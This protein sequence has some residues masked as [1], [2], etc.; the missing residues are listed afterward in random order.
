MMKKVI[1]LGLATALLTLVK[2]DVLAQCGLPWA[3]NYSVTATLDDWQDCNIGDCYDPLA[4][5]FSFDACSG[6]NHC[7]YG[8]FNGAC[9]QGTVRYGMVGP[10]FI[11]GIGGNG[12]AK[13]DLQQGALTVVGTED[14]PPDNAPYNAHFTWVADATGE[15]TFDWHYITADGPQYDP[16]YYDIG[17][18][19][20]YLTDPLGAD[21]QSGSATVFLQEGQ[22]LNLG[23][24]SVDGFFAPGIATFR[25]FTSP[26]PIPGCTNPQACNYNNISNTDDGTCFYP[27]GC[28]DPLAENYVANA[29]CEETCVYLL[30]CGRIGNESAALV[31]G[32][33]GDLDIGNWT[34]DIDSQQSGET[35]IVNSR[36]IVIST[37]GIDALYGLMSTSVTVQEDGAYVFPVDLA[38]RN[39]VDQWAIFRLG[40]NGAVVTPPE[41][42]DE[43]DNFVEHIEARLRLTLNAG[44]EVSFE[45]LQGGNLS[46]PIYERA[47]MTIGPPIHPESFSCE[48]GSDCPQDLNNDGAVGTNDI[49]EVVG[50]FGTTCP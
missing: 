2:C 11:N 41:L 34:V 17:G 49:L 12:D 39:G 7:A 30:E 15:V 13:I 36:R 8:T 48:N 24:E 1:A 46:I 26:V 40:V 35:E 43:I 31:Q 3:C 22:W 32:F 33:T 42:E 50:A 25:H 4:C 28:S 18:E 27:S 21:E 10:A 16:A 45:V 20:F 5:N 38:L 6:E 47:T 37:S 14:L 23:V 29:I 9:A 19:R 44:D